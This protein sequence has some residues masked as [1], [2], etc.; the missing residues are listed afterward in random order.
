MSILNVGTRGNSLQSTMH[1]PNTTTTKTETPFGQLMSAQRRRIP[2]GHEGPPPATDE[3]DT[4]RFPKKELPVNSRAPLHKVEKPKSN[5]ESDKA[6]KPK[7]DSKSPAQTTEPTPIPDR[8]KTDGEKVDDK[9]VIEESAETG[10]T[11][12]IK[13]LPADAVVELQHVNLEAVLA[14]IES[15][16]QELNSDVTSSLETTN[17]IEGVDQALVEL[18][19]SSPLDK[20]ATEIE[21]MS[22]KMAVKDILSKDYNEDGV[23][24]VAVKDLEQIVQGLTDLIGTLSAASENEVGVNPEKLD[25]LAKFVAKMEGQIE[26]V[27]VQTETAKNDSQELKGEADLAVE[28]VVDASTG[29]GNAS[30][31]EFTQNQSQSQQSETSEVVQT[32]SAESEKPQHLMKDEPVLKVQEVKIDG[33]VT[34]AQKSVDEVKVI[35][36]SN[37]RMQSLR[38]MTRDSVFEQ[39]KSAIMKQSFKAGD[40]SEMIIKLKPEELGKVELKIEVHKDSVIAKFNVASQMVKETIESSLSDLRNSLKDKGFSDMAFDVNVGKGKS[41]QN[42]QSGQQNARRQRHMLQSVSLE[43]RDMTYVRSLTAMVGGT[44]FEHLA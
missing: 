6:A 11:S 42:K 1:R 9:V 18:I 13:E 2:I 36:T 12:E 17:A 24:E 14:L 33:Q 27:T 26:K 35:E 4:R 40:H 15:I 7:E 22:L 38:Q 44:S 16:A 29:Q 39:V 41:E 5:G 25:M 20:L 32:A 19:D 31:Q 37:D 10:E 21:L 43:E 23:S 3:K 34:E 8:I 30:E 28:P